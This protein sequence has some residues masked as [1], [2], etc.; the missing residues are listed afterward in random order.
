MERFPFLGPSNPG[1]SVVIS[2]ER[3]VNLMP[4]IGGSKTDLAGVM[5]PGFSELSVLSPTVKPVRG[6]KVFNN[7]LYVVAGD[8]FYEVDTSYNV[9]SK[10]TLNT[11]S[12]RV[13][14]DFNPDQLMV[15]DG[16]DGWIWD[17][18]NL[19]QISDSDFTGSSA[20]QVVFHDTYFV[21]NIAGTGQFQI[22]DNND[23]TTW[24][25]LDKTTAEFKPDD[26]LAVAS[27]RE[28]FV[29]QEWTTEIYTNTGNADF[30]FEG[31]VN[32]RMVFG[33]AAPFSHARVDNTTWWL[34]RDEQGQVFVARFTGNAPAKVSTP[35]LEYT[36]S[37]FGD[38]SDAFA[39][40]VQFK[41]QYWYWITFPSAGPDGRGKSYICV[42]EAGNF[43]FEV[44]KFEAQNDDYQAHPMTAI[45]FFNNKYIMGDDKGILYEMDD[46]IFT[47]GID[48]I[49]WERRTRTIHDDRRRIF[50]HRLELDGEWGVG[51]ADESDPQ[52]RLRASDDDGRTWKEFEDVSMGKIGETRTRVRWHRLGSAYDRVYRVTG[53]DPVRTRLVAGYLDVQ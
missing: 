47:Y 13:S 25:A 22:S 14:M 18:S 36:W 15:V 31:N 52:I 11:S 37:T 28:L 43:W 46:D 34:A 17:K 1:R 9:T 33:I 44:G 19:T 5:F 53:A 21:V 41:G 39:Y 49:V 24:S 16:T 29:F 10:G 51:N 27:D 2:P 12:G 40:A 26:V 45:A 42:P 7:L 8:T 3:T 32:G 38:V 20:T 50:H 48:P 23:G 35:Q 6:M 30:P 4:E